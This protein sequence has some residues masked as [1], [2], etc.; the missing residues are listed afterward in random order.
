M[1]KFHHDRVHRARLNRSTKLSHTRLQFVDVS[2]D[3]N[4][5]IIHGIL[6]WFNFNFHLNHF[7]GMATMKENKGKEAVDEGSHP[8]IQSQ[9]RPFVGDKWKSLSK[10]LDLG[11]LPSCRGKKA[12]HGSS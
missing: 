3:L 1:S 5:N 10:N 8:E 9:A 4:T 12:K 11:N 2:L 7:S 6:F